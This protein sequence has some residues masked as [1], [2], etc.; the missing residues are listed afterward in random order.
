MSWTRNHSRQ[1]GEQRTQTRNGKAWIHNDLSPQQFLNGVAA[2][3]H[4]IRVSTRTQFTRYFGV[5]PMKCLKIVPSIVLSVGLAMSPARAA[6]QTV[7]T[8]EDTNCP[9]AVGQYGVVDYALEWNCYSFAQFPYTAHSGTNRVYTFATSAPFSFTGG[10]VS[11]DG[12]WFAGYPDATVQFALFLSN[13]PVW[14]SGILSPTDVPTFLSS[15]Y[16]GMV[17][18][19]DVLSQRPDWYI[20]DDVT[21]NGG[22]LGP[23]PEPASLVLL[24]T[25]L[26]GVF[27]VV[28]RRAA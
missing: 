5:T 6:A 25:G 18:R 28:R 1:S 8:F 20:M 21:F 9:S 17:D 22:S 11:F 24:A 10:P 16:S 19:V 27:G 12:A 7:Q 26:V 3:L 15:G 14:T 2:R 23:V 13:V 4:R